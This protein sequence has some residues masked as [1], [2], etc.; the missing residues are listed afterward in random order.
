M[1]KDLNPEYIGI[2]YDIM[3]ATAE[4][5]YSWALALKQIIPWIH[6][7]AIKDFVWEKREKEWQP[8]YVPLGEG[9]D[10]PNLMIA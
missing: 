9:M 4:G 1:L 5:G 10:R 2:Q 6:S 8:N 7:L 3:H